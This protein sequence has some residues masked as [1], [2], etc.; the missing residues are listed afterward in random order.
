M[1]RCSGLCLFCYFFCVCECFLFF[2]VFSLSL[3]LALEVNR[4]VT[5]GGELGLFEDRALGSKRRDV[6]KL[7][8]PTT[9]IPQSVTAMYL[10]EAGMGGGAGRG[11]EGFKADHLQGHFQRLMT[12]P[13]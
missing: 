5:D 10:G 4:S 2:L 7:C 8:P 12:L 1:L 13:G 6:M 9:T 3:D 11:L